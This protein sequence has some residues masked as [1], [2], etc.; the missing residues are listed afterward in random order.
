MIQGQTVSNSGAEGISVNLQNSA[1]QDNASF[2]I[3]NSVTSSV[4][5]GILITAN[6]SSAVGMTLMANGSQSNTGNGIDI[7]GN[8]SFLQNM[9]VAGGGGTVANVGLD[10]TMDGFT[11]TGSGGWNII[12][13]STTPGENVT[14]FSVNLAT[15]VTNAIFNTVAGAATPFTPFGGTDVS[16]G[17]LTVNGTA[18]PPYPPPLVAD[19][20]QL[21]DMTWNNFAPGKNFQWDIDT[22]LTVGGDEVTTG[23][24]LIGST[25]NVGFTG[26]ATLSG[27][28]VALPSDPTAG[29]HFVATSGM[30][31]GRRSPE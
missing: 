19:F 31:T 30:R 10:F 7:V 14:S 2:L 20:S 18:V 9:T 13:T 11:N 3:S 24:D 8:N 22:D 26:G 15:S 1:I 4:G 17:L 21:L 12:N 23:A 28:L 6:N 25:V 16:T 27:T 29:S 5:D